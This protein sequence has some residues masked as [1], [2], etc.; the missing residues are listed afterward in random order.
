LHAATLVMAL[1]SIV[2]LL[3]TIVVYGWS[4]W[5]GNPVQKE[6]PKQQEGFEKSETKAELRNMVDRVKLVE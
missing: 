5:Y 6:L 3:L 1:F 4:W 2:I